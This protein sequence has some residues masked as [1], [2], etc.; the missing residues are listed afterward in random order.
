MNKVVKQTGFGLDL[1]SEWVELVLEAKE[2]GITTEE[3][4]HFLDETSQLERESY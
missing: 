2:I 1:D 4:R 3:V